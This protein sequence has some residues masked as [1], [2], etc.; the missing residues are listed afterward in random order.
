MLLANM[1]IPPPCRSSMQRTSYMVSK[2]ITDINT[3]DMA[4][5]VE[6]IKE[7]NTKRDNKCDEINIAMDG[8]TIPPQ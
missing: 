3:K 5:K 4:S 1:D 6:L 2:T 7:I 8:D